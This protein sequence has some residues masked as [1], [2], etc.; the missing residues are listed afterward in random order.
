MRLILALGDRLCQQN[1]M[2]LLW[3]KYRRRLFIILV[4]GC[5]GFEHR[6]IEILQAHEI[7]Y[8][9]LEDVNQEQDVAIQESRGSWSASSDSGGSYIEK[10]TT[11]T[12]D[13]KYFLFRNDGIIPLDESA[14]GDALTPQINVAGEVPVGVDLSND[15]LTRGIL[16][17]GKEYAFSICQWKRLWLYVYLYE[18]SFDRFSWQTSWSVYVKYD[19]SNNFEFPWFAPDYVNKPLQARLLREQEIQAQ[20]EL[21]RRSAMEKA[22]LAQQSQP[23]TLRGVLVGLGVILQLIFGGFL[24]L[25]VIAAFMNLGRG[26]GGGGGGG[27]YSNEFTEVNTTK[28]ENS[29]E[30]DSSGPRGGEYVRIISV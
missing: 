29:K 8:S 27:S 28:D 10:E 13:V 11:Q 23:L 6:N 18:N 9:I 19:L 4:I 7:I 26:G 15:A 5:L 2:S 14:C 25:L 20:L 30:T 1:P 21:Q 22:R 3:L 12:N 16:E 17:R 24:I